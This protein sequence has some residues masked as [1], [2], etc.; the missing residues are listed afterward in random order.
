MPDEACPGGY[1]LMQPWL[2]KGECT[3]ACRPDGPACP[4][5]FRCRELP[6]DALLPAVCEAEGGDEFLADVGRPCPGGYGCAGAS[7]CRITNT[8]CTGG[9]CVVHTGPLR[10]YCSAR[11][12]EGVDGA[13]RCPEGYACGTEDGAR[14]CLEQ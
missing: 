8:D 1:C 12:Y 14:V 3:S 6:A 9:F 4:D 2:P 7:T 13:P 11:C 5:G 10:A